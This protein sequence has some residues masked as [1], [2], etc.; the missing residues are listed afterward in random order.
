M[1]KAWPS[2]MKAGP[3]LV[4]MLRSSIARCTSV[5]A[6]RPV[7]KSNANFA[8]N[9]PPM[10]SN[11]SAREATATGRRPQNPLIASGEYTN[12]RS[13]PSAPCADAH[14]CLTGMLYAVQPKASCCILAGVKAE[15]LSKPERFTTFLN[16]E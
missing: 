15:Y 13:A 9:E 14:K 12:G 16:I 5:A 8:K 6:S 4:T 2:L 7:K 11:C 10:P 1:D 3:R